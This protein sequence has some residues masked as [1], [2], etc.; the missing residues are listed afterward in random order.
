MPTVYTR[1]ATFSNGDVIDAPLFNAEFDQLVD[2]SADLNA[3]VTALADNLVL[4]ESSATDAATAAGLAQVAAE[5]AET[6]AE[7]AAELLP[8][9]VAT[10]SKADFFALAE[11]RI[12]ESAGSGFSEWG[13]Q[14]NDG[15][16]TPVNNGMT[17]NVAIPNILRL[18]YDFNV[19]VSRTQYSIVNINGVA[20][21]ISS[22]N[23][24]SEALSQF[25][26]PPAPNGTKTRDSANGVVVQHADSATAFAA[27][28]ATNK[29]IISRKDF[30]FIESWPELVSE[31]DVVYP[32][33]NT[34][35]GVSTWKGI[36]LSNALVAQ[37]YSAFGAW[38]TVT[39]GYGV[40]WS[41]LSEANKLIFLQDKYNNMYT[42]N[43]VPYQ[44]R[45][46]ARVVEGQTDTTGVVTSALTGGYA[47]FY[48]MDAVNASDGF[49]SPQGKSVV[50][51]D[52][53]NDLSIGGTF[54]SGSYSVFDGT[55]TILPKG[56]LV[57]SK[58]V[59]TGTITGD[60][61]FGHN[62]LC[63]SI[64]VA[65]VQRRNQGGY[66]PTYNS[67]GCAGF[68]A[69]GAINPREWW[70][71][72]VIASGKLISTAACFVFGE[73]NG[74]VSAL[75]GFIAST[76]TGNE[77]GRPDGKFYDAI[78]ASDVKDNRMSTEDLS[79]SE[80]RKKNR[81]NAK[82]GE[83]RGFEGVPFTDHFD[84]GKTGASTGLTSSGIMAYDVSD[85]NAAKYSWIGK[86]AG[87]TN[88]L[89]PTVGG[90][91]I[92]GV[93]YG[94]DGAMRHATL[95]N[96]VYLRLKS[97]A[98]IDANGLSVE[99]VLSSFTKSH[100][101]AKPYWTDIVGDPA[102]IAAT[103][104]N[105][106][107]GQWIP[108]IPTGVALPFALNRKCTDLDVL[109]TYTGDN[110]ATWVS[111]T[112][113][114][115]SGTTNT[116]TSGFTANDVALL[117]YT[118]QAHFTQDAVNSK[119]LDLGGVFATHNAG[120]A[121]LVSSLIDK[122]AKN[123]AGG[124]WQIDG[125]LNRY[126]LDNAGLVTNPASW[127]VLNVGSDQKP[128]HDTINITLPTG[129]AVKTLDYLSSL[130][131]VATLNYA[132]KEMVYDTGKDTVSD[133]TSVNATISNSYVAGTYYYFQNEGLVWLCVTSI[134]ST[135][136]GTGN[137]TR[138]GDSII[139]NSNNNV[140]FKLWNG[141]GFGD[142]NKF[143]IIDNQAVLTDDN[144]KP[145]LYGSALFYTQHFIRER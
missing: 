2:V 37:G 22:T 90:V 63:F 29:V 102:N 39:T 101:Q 93:S 136:R 55:G 77:S 130:N 57:A 127:G 1:Q 135:V 145:A 54:L 78:Y 117:Q 111:N 50:P 121:I 123:G 26:F 81:E 99:V 38:D 85:S 142:N 34:Q 18:G 64:P 60:A 94:V 129:S 114:T 58:T 124:T 75:T 56:T 92:N 141:N 89:T 113:G 73:A 110:G 30:A 15:T 52:S 100:K 104:P 16:F 116:D 10:P 59:L 69:N 134:T 20:A 13:K 6:N 4:L 12:R 48:K 105:G 125:K 96:L 128:T 5:L 140:Y 11:Q 70:T 36:T 67:N 53:T 83:I 65:T 115:F 17:A 33:G 14:R 49:I 133:F 21:R 86:T 43:G 51:V 25:T 28:T 119:V 35:Y 80:I 72:N 79:Y 3:Y 32:L 91:V 138:I 40:V 31:K 9:S 42:E 107:E 118:T 74:E 19:G 61:S 71:A 103:F 97:R 46:R 45:Y 66:H 137:W 88:A 112:G 108:V 126:S 95:T 84:L 109:R 76:T 132:Y 62:G 144:G 143:E 23:I 120:N 24:N 139:L 7:S 44:V 41:T 8:T 82:S 27:E 131:G 47:R 106:V 87:T 122:I 98:Q 68:S